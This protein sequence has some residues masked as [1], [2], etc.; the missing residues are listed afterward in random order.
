MKKR[1]KPILLVTVL[2]LMVG[3]VAFINFPRELLKSSPAPQSTTPETG[4]KIDVPEKEEIAKNVS[5]SFG[6]PKKAQPAIKKRP[7]PAGPEGEMDMG[8]S[9]A[10]KKMAPYKPT[11]NESST[12]TQ[13]YSDET[14]KEIPKPKK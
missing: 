11:P 6:D 3:A 10:I 12:S 1:N 2:V 7:S 5:T 8:P 14:L 13:W 9:I 4:Q